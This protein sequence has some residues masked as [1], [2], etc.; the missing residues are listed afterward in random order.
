MES[1]SRRD[2]YADLTRAAIISAAVTRFAADGFAG[3]SI[4]AVAEQARVSKGAVYH[5]FTDKAELFEA[6][7][8]AMEE[9]L[10]ADVGAAL[11][12]IDDP[13]QLIAAGTDA[14]LAQ[15][16]RPD[17]CR[18]ALQ[19]AP[20]AL[21]W[22]RWKQVEERYFLGLVTAG[23]DN[24][25]RAG[26]IDVPSTPIAARMFL[27]AAGEAGLTLATSPNPA[28]DRPRMADLLMRLLTGLRPAIGIEGLPRPGD[29][30]C[31]WPCRVPV[32]SVQAAAALRCLSTGMTSR[33]N[34]RASSRE[35]VPM[36]SRRAPVSSM[37]CWRA[38]TT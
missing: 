3:T 35:K 15:C 29:Y 25:A 13:W 4:D 1:K 2:E 27:A 32:A 20:A 12:G 10:L 38:P 30:Q 14:F 22:Q 31:Q 21:G 8:I 28:A 26:L 16:G 18:I 17:F 36:S 24:L 23:L 37:T 34:S 33:A 6:A 9:R 7:F 5:H 11:A 19:E